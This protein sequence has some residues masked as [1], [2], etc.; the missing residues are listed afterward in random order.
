MATCLPPIHTGMLATS[1][2]VN[3]PL[4][5]NRK[6]LTSLLRTT[7]NP[8]LRTCRSM[9]CSVYC[10]ISVRRQAVSGTAWSETEAVA[11]GELS[12]SGPPPPNTCAS[13]ASMVAS[14]KN[15]CFLAV[16][17][18]APDPWLAWLFT[19]S[20]K[21]VPFHFWESILPFCS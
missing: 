15:R 14:S 20:R 7:L 17:W 13:K 16:T 2:E 6:E 5:P 19:V 11:V 8:V 1:V 9:S 10:P 4:L 12:K 21:V 3:S 18:R